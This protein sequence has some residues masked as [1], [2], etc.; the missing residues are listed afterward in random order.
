MPVGRDVPPHVLTSYKTNALSSY[1]QYIRV[2]PAISVYR[3][4]IQNWYALGGSWRS[5]KGNPIHRV[6]YGRYV[7]PSDSFGAGHIGK[8]NSTLD[9]IS[10]ECCSGSIRIY[11]LY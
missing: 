10:K 2:Q 4:V 6:V 7:L 8:Y 5:C 1:P 11:V 9:V 3:Y